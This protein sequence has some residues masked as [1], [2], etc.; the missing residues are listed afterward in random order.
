MPPGC[1]GR[2]PSHGH[3]PGDV[4]ERS[5]LG[6]PAGQR[7]GR[8]GTRDADGWVCRT[9][10]RRAVL[11]LMPGCVCGP[12]SGE[13]QAMQGMVQEVMPYVEKMPDIETKVELIKTNSSRTHYMVA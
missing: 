2:I 11:M 1:S 10:A 7:L 4:S 5:P 9:E 6:W 13:L 12:P 3:E 8:Q